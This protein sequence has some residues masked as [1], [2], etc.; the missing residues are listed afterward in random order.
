MTDNSRLCKVCQPVISTANLKIAVA[1][2]TLKR[3]F[4]RGD[5]EIT[6]TH[7]ASF[8]DLRRSAKIGCPLCT[9]LEDLFSNLHHSQGR[10]DDNG[11]GQASFIFCL[12]YAKSSHPVF[13]VSP[14]YIFRMVYKDSLLLDDFKNSV[15]I[16]A[17]G[18]EGESIHKK[19]W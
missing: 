15:G 17:I 10:N 16:Y 12:K 13:P 7:H 6:Y 5:K 8:Q 1:D 11:C 14:T 9:I 4:F 3:D 18:V 2:F 19:I